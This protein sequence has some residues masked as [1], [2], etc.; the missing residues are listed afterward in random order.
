MK[1]SRMSVAFC[2]AVFPLLSQAE[3]ETIDGFCWYY[4]VVGDGAEI[5]SPSEFGS[6]ED[7]TWADGRSLTVPDCLGGKPVVSIGD[8]A[9]ANG[10]FP[11]I[12]LP[13]TVTNIGEY[14][15]FSLPLQSFS[16][17]SRL[18]SIGNCAFANCSSL[19]DINLPNSLTSLGWGAFCFTGI[20]S[21]SIPTGVTD[22]Q[23]DTFANC[24]SLSSVTFHDDVKSIQFGAFRSCSLKTVVLPKNLERLEQDAFSYSSGAIEEVIIPEKLR[25]LD[26]AVFRNSQVYRLTIP[27]SDLTISRSSDDWTMISF[28]SAPWSKV[29]SLMEALTL[30]EDHGNGTSSTFW[31][32]P[33]TLEISDAVKE[34]PDGMFKGNGGIEHFLWPN[35]LKRIGKSAFE[36]CWNMTQTHLPETV[37]TIDDYAFRGCNCFGIAGNWTGSVRLDNTVVI[38][39]SVKYIGRQAFHP[40]VENVEQSGGSVSMVKFLFKG[41]PP[42]CH[43]EAFTNYVYALTSSLS[44]WK[45]TAGYYLPAYEKEWRAVIDANGEFCGLPMHLHDPNATTLY[46]TVDGLRWPYYVEN[47]HSI[48]GLYDG[49]ETP[50]WQRYVCP[51]ASLKGSDGNVVIPSTLGGLP[52]T[53]INSGVFDWRAPVNSLTIPASVS[54]L[55][56]GL[57]MSFFAHKGNP[58]RIRFCGWPPKN[59]EKTN[60]MRMANL[61]EYP[62]SKEDVWLVFL[63]ENELSVNAVPYDDSGER[64]TGTYDRELKVIATPF[65]GIYD[66][67]PHTVSVQVDGAYEL[68]TVKYAT[69]SRG[70]YTDRPPTF[71]G[72]CTNSPV[73]YCV[74]AKNCR[75][76][77]GCEYVTIYQNI[78]RV[79]LKTPVPVP[80]EWLKGVY[81]LFDN[82]NFEAAAQRYTG[83]VDPLIGPLKAW[84]EYVMGT[85]P[86]DPR[87]RFSARLERKDDGGFRVTWHPDKSN[88]HH[89]YEIFAKRTLFDPE[90][91]AVPDPENPPPGYFFFAARVSLDTFMTSLL[92]A[93]RP[94]AYFAGDIN[95]DGTLSEADLSQLRGHLNYLNALES[96]ISESRISSGKQLVGSALD[97]ADV[98]GDGMV[99]RDDERELKSLLSLP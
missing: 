17:P 30:K 50:T 60:L 39:A 91:T 29:P 79:T 59:L 82:A 40:K 2:M 71:T 72:V 58:S 48:L 3:T 44:P 49:V 92:N 57:T 69:S 99:D 63:A 23:F 74:S 4:K 53:R 36:N 16:F 77:S 9:F 78:G 34:I 56:Q 98:N 83:K 96:G 27:T 97:A 41:R 14:A 26:F 35:G 88:E 64:D 6:S 1:L 95:G 70:P 31:Y 90:W 45:S 5:M 76:V 22:I 24:S 46:E 94:S 12:S 11:A 7:S 42:S 13:N 55:E 62:L 18:I 32:G 19:T 65:A 20:S 8:N 73:Y 43:A 85:D 21:V 33:Q 54:M 84:Q 68:L 15:F 75:T 47:G 86:S 67:K 81:K 89:V 93:Q 66:G 28:V 51:V 52:V 37:E 87:S 80:V 10:N 25:N 38:P 61:Y